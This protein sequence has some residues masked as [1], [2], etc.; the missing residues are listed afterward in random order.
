MN[1][2]G[3]TRTAPALALALAV[4]LAPPALAAG[5]CG[6]T[7]A[8][9][10]SGAT[11]TCTY[12]S[13]GEDTFGGPTLAGVSSVTV[14][15]IGGSGGA[16]AFSGPAGGMGAKVQASLSRDFTIPLYAEVGS[17]G[18]DGGI[19]A[20]GAGGANGGG[21]TTSG[22]SGD[23]GARGGGG[24][25]ASD[26]RATPEAS[27][28]SLDSRLLVAGGGGGGAAFGGTGG[29]AG[30]GAAFGG[31]PLVVGGGDGSGDP[32]AFGTGG[33]TT[34]GN[35]GGGP[36]QPSSGTQGT[37]GYG[38]CHGGGGGAGYYGGGGGN[39]GG[40]PGGG[41]AGSSMGPTG[42]QIQPAGSGDVPSVTI[43]YTVV[44]PN[45]LCLLTKQDVEGSAAFKSLP[46]R[47]QKVGD[48]LV[49]DACAKL[50]NLLP[51]T[52]GP[53]KTALIALYDAGVKLLGTAGFLSPAQAAQLKSLAA[54]L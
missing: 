27:A 14:V 21:G 33:T 45:S 32:G 52:S 36:C 7:G 37:G 40:T 51:G 4:A 15:A 46:T 18:Q 12:T 53:R 48:Q 38:Q 50:G 26:L 8:P 43:T 22:G 6:S 20:G 17:R 11:A 35:G 3:W 49:T 5:P 47:L 34:G 1:I 24:G 13:A 25:G 16:A 39:N 44:T 19:S 30:T 41:G 2:H 54:L 9:S 23:F 42:A 29:T 10:T 28:A 31:P